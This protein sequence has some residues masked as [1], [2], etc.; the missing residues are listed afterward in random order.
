MCLYIQFFFK[1]IN[2]EEIEGFKWEGHVSPTCVT[3]T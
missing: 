2:K 1:K 3:S